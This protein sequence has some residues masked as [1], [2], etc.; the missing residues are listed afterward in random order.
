MIRGAGGG[1]G[2]RLAYF[3]AEIQRVN[4]AGDRGEM[5]T[6]DCSRR[7]REA[8]RAGPLALFL[9]CA[10]SVDH[11]GI[12]GAAG[13]AGAGGEAGASGTTGGGAGVSATGAAG[14][15]GTTGGVGA[16]AGTGG[17]GGPVP[18]GGMGGDGA[19]AGSGG[20]EGIAGTNGGA[21]DGPGGGAGTGPAGNAGEGGGAGEGEHGGGSGGSA[22]GGAGGIGG[23][24]GA[25]GAGGEGAGG[26]AGTGV[27]GT[28]GGEGGA[29]GEGARG[30]AGG[31]GFGGR[32]GAGGTFGNC[33]ACAPCTRCT[34]GTCALD[35]TSLWKVRCIRAVIAQTKPTGEPWDGLVS[36]TLAA[37]DPKCSFWLGNASASETSVLSNT[38]T[39]EWNES[40][41]PGTRFMASLLSSQSS[42]WS[43]RVTDD[44][45]AAGEEPICSV[46]PVLDVGVF[47]TRSD[48]FS[49]GSCTT[50][51]IGLDCVSP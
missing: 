3:R 18:L 48:T 6:G 42:P 13:A 29:S 33:G 9:I 23:E 45:Q 20:P 21:G 16:K 12:G 50:L 25:G 30:G 4:R 5:P 17:G 24:A 44:D 46:S 26:A 27:A 10:C 19:I 8:L 32:G 40:I 7:L 51:E 43:I 49:A 34:N 36:G 31:S 38:Y 1:N 11:A 47:A 14:T 37:P 15:G 39:P 41:T 28:G 35:P 2:W 22:G